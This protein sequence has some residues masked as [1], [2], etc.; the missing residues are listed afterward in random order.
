MTPLRQ[1]MLEDIAIG[2]SRL[3]DFAEGGVSFR[4][5]DYRHESRQKV[6]RLDAHEFIRRFLLHVLPNGL[7][8]IRHYGFLANRY[9]AVKLARCR[10]LIAQPEPVVASPEAPVDYR[11]RYCAADALMCGNGTVAT[12]HPSE[13]FGEDWMSWGLAARK[14]EEPAEPPPRQVS[15]SRN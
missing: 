5:K 2:N 12:L 14:D 10:E 4:W 8:R 6:M 11:D 3:I 15:A 9:R 13:L 1:R 7:Q